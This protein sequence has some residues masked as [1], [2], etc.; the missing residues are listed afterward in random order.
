VDV[1]EERLRHVLP[2]VTGIAARLTLAV[3]K[4]QNVAVAPLLRRAG[5]SEHD[6]DGRQHRISAASHAK[7]F[8][9]AA[10]AVDDGAFGLHLAEDPVQQH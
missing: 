6:L 1:T 10:D 2:T 8:E 9:F 4:K 5:I 3:L 7:F